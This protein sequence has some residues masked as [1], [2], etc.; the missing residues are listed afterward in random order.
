MYLTRKLSRSG[1]RMVRKA[2]FYDL[3]LSDLYTRREWVLFTSSRQWRCRWQ[4]FTSGQ[5]KESNRSWRYFLRSDSH[6]CFHE[7]AKSISARY[8]YEGILLRRRW[9]T[10][11]AAVIL[12]CKPQSGRCLSNKAAR[13]K[14]ALESEQLSCCRRIPRFRRER[15]KLQR[16]K[17]SQTPS[18]ESRRRITYLVPAGPAI[19][20]SIFNQH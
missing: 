17:Q 4:L 20:T 3:F 16:I 10:D 8:S 14:S 2:S 7:A 9:N 19:Y 12:R 6:H 15:A 13:L 1:F 18:L 11:R 5:G